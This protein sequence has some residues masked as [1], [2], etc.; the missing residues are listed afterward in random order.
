MCSQRSVVRRMP[1]ST[2]PSAGRA[3]GRVPLFL[4]DFDR[5]AREVPLLVNLRPS[6]E[7]YMQDFHAAGGVP[8]LLKVLEPML[9]TDHV[10]VSGQ[11]LAEHL[12]SVE[13][14]PAPWQRRFT[15]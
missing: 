12:A 13:P 5:L 9:A 8:T 6:G 1:S 3:P 11:T 14:P 15:P 10:G 7:D 4:D 2:C